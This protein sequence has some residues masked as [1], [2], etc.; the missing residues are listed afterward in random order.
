MNNT[1][2]SVSLHLCSCVS[3][4]VYSIHTSFMSFIWIVKDT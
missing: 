4:K 2:R 1:M 3:V